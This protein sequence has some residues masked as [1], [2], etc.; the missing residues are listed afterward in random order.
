[1]VQPEVVWQELVRAEHD[2]AWARFYRCFHWRR[3]YERGKGAAILEPILSVTWSIAHAFGPQRE[4][5]ET[6]LNVKMHRAL[7]RCTKPDLRLLVLDWQH[8][9]YWFWPQRFADPTVREA[10][11]VPVLPDSDYYIFLAEDFGFGLFGHP[12]EKTICVFGQELLTVL[13]QGRPQ[14]LAKRERV[15]QD[16]KPIF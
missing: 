5:L 12:W 10:W 9:C 14:L 11:K 15:R 7:R 8:T 1:M 6:D 4:E 16:G 13:D 3:E 2:A